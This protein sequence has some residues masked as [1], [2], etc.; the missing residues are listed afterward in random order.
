MESEDCAEASAS[1]HTDPKL[2]AA[3]EYSEYVNSQ[4]S[5]IKIQK[6][7]TV[8]QLRKSSSSNVTGE[9]RS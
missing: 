6:Y 8:E 7:Q 2:A 9:T 3:H 4:R 1:R 5:V